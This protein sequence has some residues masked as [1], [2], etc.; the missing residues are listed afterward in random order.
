MNTLIRARGREFKLGRRDHGEGV[1]I[2]DGQ[3]PIEISLSKGNPGHASLNHA[4]LRVGRPHPEPWSKRKH[5]KLM[6]TNTG[7]FVG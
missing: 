1:A 4:S 2:E 6:P 7:V 3:A 5:S